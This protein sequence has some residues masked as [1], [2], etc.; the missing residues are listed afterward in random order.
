MYTHTHARSHPPTN[1][2]PPPPTH[3]HI[4]FLAHQQLKTF[5]YNK[6]KF[7]KQNTNSTV[8]VW[9]KACLPPLYG[10]SVRQSVPPSPVRC[11][12]DKR[13]VSLLF[14][15]DTKCVF[16]LCT[17]SVSHKACLPALYGFSVTQSVSPSSLRCQ[18]DTKRVSLLFTVSV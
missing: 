2:P 11:Q 17:A 16:Q 12:C 18:Y 13:C 7:L 1:S 4:I 15:C 6:T 9:H 8:S 5:N 10:G 14:Q 3:T